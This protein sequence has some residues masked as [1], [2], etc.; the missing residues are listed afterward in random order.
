MDSR[1]QPNGFTLIETLV[2]IGLVTIL[3]AAVIVGLDPIGRLQRA[4]DNRRLSDLE[5]I[6]AAITVYQSDNE[7]SI[8]PGIDSNVR[9]LGTAATGCAESFSWEGQNYTSES[10]CLDL[11]GV[12]SSY[13]ASIP[14][15]PE[16]GSD[17]KTFYAV[18]NQN[19]KVEVMAVSYESGVTASPAPSASPTTSPTT[20]PSPSPSPTIIPSPS[21]SPTIIPSPSPSPTPAA[22]LEVTFDFTSEWGSGYCVDIL[23][24]NT[25]NATASTWFLTFDPHDSTL[26][27]TFGGNFTTNGPYYE[28]TPL[29][30]NAEIVPGATMSDTGYCANKT[31]SNFTP[32]LVSIA[33]TNTAPPSPTP[34][35]IP[36][37]SPAVLTTSID[38]SSEWS[39][40]YCADITI[41]NNGPGDVNSWELIFNPNDSTVTGSWSGNFTFSSPNYVVTPLSWN[42]QITEGTSINS[43]GFCADKTGSNFTPTVISTTEQ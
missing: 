4:R 10:S 38:F 21:P 7:G 40:G 20:V 43:P 13:L 27:S 17:S 1:K 32:T 30:Y 24:T 11:S 5:T 6:G 2:T 42:Q 19:E 9:I 36:S 33:D 22:V 18:Q 23:I 12:L 29:S 8:P 25:G 16:T 35:P 34:S 28:V 39:T 41:T 15:D 14:F 3:A 26:T 37:P 31:G